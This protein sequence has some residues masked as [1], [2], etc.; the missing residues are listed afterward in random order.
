ML[1][2]KMVRRGKMVGALSRLRARVE[3]VKIVGAGNGNIMMLLMA[4][5]VVVVVMVVVVVAAAV[6]VVVVMMMMMVMMIVLSHSNSI[7]RA[8]R[9]RAG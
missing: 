4:I 8:C 5:L 2:K 9:G 1:S 3:K 6:V 7:S